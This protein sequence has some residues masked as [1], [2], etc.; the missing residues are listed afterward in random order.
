MTEA[1]VSK[2]IYN[3]CSKSCELDAILTTLLKQILLGHHWSYNQD[4]KPVTYHWSL[5]TI[6]KITVIHPLLKKTGFGV[7]TKEL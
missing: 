1:E 7:N 4:H 2:I 5:L 6:L 3:M